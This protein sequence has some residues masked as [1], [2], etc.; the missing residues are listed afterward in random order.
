MPNECEA[1][2]VH[3][4]L[5][6]SS[7]SPKKDEVF[8]WG[9]SGELSCCP[10]N[11]GNRTEGVHLI[12]SAS[13][14]SPKKDEVFFWG[15]SGEL[16]CCPTNVGNRTE[17][18]TAGAT[19]NFLAS[20]VGAGQISP[21]LFH[22]GRALIP[23]PPFPTNLLLR[24]IFAGALLGRWQPKGL[25]EG[26]HLILSASSGS[27]KK[28]EVFFWGGSGELSCCPTNVG[29]RTEGV[30]AGA[31][32]NFLASRVGAGQISPPL[33]HRGRALMP[34]PPFPTNLLLTQNLCGNPKREVAAQRADGRSS[35][36]FK[37]PLEG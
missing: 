1:E 31:T 7:G 24:K 13:S 9:G 12:L 14:R 23:A 35:P 27:P 5:S 10:T 25:T 26:V 33:F 29:N 28:D 11:V 6:A 36:H 17:G 2:G 15:G 3:L 32:V 8:F 34:A 30:T 16:S 18:V 4:I 20:R 22:R 21:P 19:I 37:R